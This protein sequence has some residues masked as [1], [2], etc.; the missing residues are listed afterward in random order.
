M[1]GK[2]EQLAKK[3]KFEGELKGALQNVKKIEEKEKNE[4]RQVKAART[5]KPA[6]KMIALLDL[7][8]K[9]KL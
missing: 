3:V 4:Q 8:R 5:M 2:F 1:P 7:T 9:K 6:T